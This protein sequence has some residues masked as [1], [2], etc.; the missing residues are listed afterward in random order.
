MHQLILQICVEEQVEYSN[1]QGLTDVTGTT[2]LFFDTKSQKV[3]QYQFSHL[4]NAKDQLTLLLQTYLQGQRQ[5]LLLNGEIAEKAFRQS[6][7]SKRV[8]P[9][10][11]DQES[12]EKLWNDP[13]AFKPLGSD[14]YIQYFWPKCPLFEQCQQQFEQ[15][16][17][18]MYE[19]LEKVNVN[20]LAK[21]TAEQILKQTPQQI[22]QKASVS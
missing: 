7:K 21:K 2:G 11:F 5:A 1:E 18:P 16:Y 22:N 6:G 8:E 9:P 12:F 19:S 15:V 10:H 14:N 20:T 3:T 4:A 13:N 17:Q